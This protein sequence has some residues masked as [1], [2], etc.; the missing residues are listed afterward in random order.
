[1]KE[2]DF[3]LRVVEFDEG[4]YLST[5]MDQV[6]AGQLVKEILHNKQFADRCKKDGILTYDRDCNELRYLVKSLLNDNF[7]IEAPED[8]ID[9]CKHLME[10]MDKKK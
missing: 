1:M 5:G 2:E 7:D 8:C 4:V 9:V 10:F 3:D 6:E